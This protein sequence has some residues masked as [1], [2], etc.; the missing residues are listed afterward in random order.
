[1][2]RRALLAAA[3]ASTAAGFTVPASSAATRGGR[4]LAAFDDRFAEVEGFDPLNLSSSSDESSANGQSR[5]ASAIAAATAILAASPLSA[6]AA[7]PDW[8]VFEGRTGSLLHPLAMFSMAAMSASTALLGFQ[9]RRQRTLGDEISALKK[10][11]PD[12][13]GASS[14]KEAIAAAESAEEV[15]AS[16]VSALKGALSTEG[17]IEELTRERKELAASG[18]RDKHFN[19]GSLLLFVG[20]AFAIEVRSFCELSYF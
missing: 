20:I 6:S 1:M 8:G 2:I 15:D 12:L 19:Q 4:G 7:G 9:W 10:T 18:P 3:L 17:Q 16:Y 14:V 11:L 5:T 13:N